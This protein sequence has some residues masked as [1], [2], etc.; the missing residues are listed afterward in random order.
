MVLSFS[1]FGDIVY[2]SSL[3][4]PQL[5][6]FIIKISK[7]MMDV[8]EVSSLPAI[9]LHSDLVSLYTGTVLG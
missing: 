6:K 4:V 7:R 8:C 1:F 5:K 9:L 2:V 3:F